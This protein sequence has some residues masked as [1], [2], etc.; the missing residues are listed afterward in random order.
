MNF[1]LIIILTGDWFCQICIKHREQAK[2]IEIDEEKKN[3][4]T[5]EN[6]NKKK[7]DG[8]RSRDEDEDDDNVPLKKA[9]EDQQ[10]R[11][12]KNSSNKYSPTKSCPFPGC[13]GSGNIKKGSTGHF[14]VKACPLAREEKRREKEL[15]VG[16]LS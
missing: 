13:D 2:Q 5:N 12:L 11:L 16:K 6:K 8:K 15:L 3:G 10:E 9:T 14:S 7:E 1:L 4:Q